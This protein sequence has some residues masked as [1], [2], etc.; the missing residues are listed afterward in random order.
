[1]G[2]TRDDFKKAGSLEP[3]SEWNEPY[4]AKDGPVKRLTQRSA[5]PERARLTYQ[6]TLEPFRKPANAAPRKGV[7]GQVKM[8]DR[9]SDYLSAHFSFDEFVFSDTAIRL[10]IDNMPNSDQIANIKALCSSVL[11]PARLT[12]GA[13]KVNS[14]YRSPDLNKLVGG[15]PTSEHM[16]QG[17]HAAADI[18]PL[19][20]TVSLPHLYAY[21]RSRLVFNQLIFEFSSWVHVSFRR[22]GE[23]RNECL[24][25]Y[26]K[27]GRTHYRPVDYKDGLS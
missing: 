23:N 15:S 27:D 1:M 14:G 17:D 4:L 21:I 12:L 26:L 16:C 20:P 6:P 9:G 7:L 24:V 11:E 3:L 5:P 13:I 22:V 19:S 10:G 18:R 2:A 25:S 8:I